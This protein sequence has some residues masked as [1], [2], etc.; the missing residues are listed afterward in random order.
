MLGLG[1]WGRTVGPALALHAVTE[2]RD[3]VPAAPEPALGRFSRHVRTGQGALSAARANPEGAA[4][5]RNPGLRDDWRLDEG[6]DRDASRAAPSWAW[7]I[8]PPPR[9]RVTQEEGPHEAG[10]ETATGTLDR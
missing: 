3:P 9:A 4:R 5:T 8:H 10:T 7:T 2:A 6:D 1:R